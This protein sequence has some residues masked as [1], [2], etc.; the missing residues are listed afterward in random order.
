MWAC[1]WHDPDWI[2][3]S[4]THEDEARERGWVVLMRRQFRETVFPAIEGTSLKEWRLPARWH[5]DT[6]YLCPAC[7][8]D[9]E[10]RSHYVGWSAKEN[11]EAWTADP[12]TNERTTVSWRS[13][14][15]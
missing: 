3:Q 4:A 10:C 9:P 5:E 15:S 7:A 1:D 2:E 11:A 6:V 14:P 8:R 12:T 13:L